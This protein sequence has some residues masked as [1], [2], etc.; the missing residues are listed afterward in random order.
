M[1]K[2]YPYFCFK[3]KEPDLCN[4]AKT[5]FNKG[6]LKIALPCQLLGDEARLKL[7][8][9]NLS[10]KECKSAITVNRILS[11]TIFAESRHN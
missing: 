6:V 8:E 3:V 7:S 9:N 11:S 1:L 5:F 2:S 10:E 4:G